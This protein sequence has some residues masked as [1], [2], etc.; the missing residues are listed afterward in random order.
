MFNCQLSD[1]ILSKGL[2]DKCDSIT[3][4]IDIYNSIGKPIYPENL[5]LIFR[6]QVRGDISE[7]MIKFGPINVIFGRRKPHLTI[8]SFGRLNLSVTGGYNLPKFTVGAP[9]VNLLDHG[10]K[11]TTV[12]KF[13]L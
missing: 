6:N 7:G 12:L 3:M 10:Q 5:T 1:I 4:D 13:L 11:T 9:L 2:F 8:I